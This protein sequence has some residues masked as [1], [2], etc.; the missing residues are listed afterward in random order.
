[1]TCYVSNEML[2]PT[3]SLITQSLAVQA[4]IKLGREHVTID[5]INTL[6]LRDFGLII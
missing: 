1:M 3:H 4:S 2:N 5:F 6:W